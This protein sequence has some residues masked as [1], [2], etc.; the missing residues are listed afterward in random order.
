MKIPFFSKNRKDVLE[1]KALRLWVKARR[2]DLAARRP[3]DTFGAG[4]YQ[5]FF[6]GQGL[7]FHQVREYVPGDDVRFLDWNVTARMGHPYLKTFVEERELHLLIVLDASP[8]LYQSTGAFGKWEAALSAAAGLSAAAQRNRD[9]T[10]LLIFTDRVEVFSPPRRGRAAAYR[11]IREMVRLRPRA[12]KADWSLALGVA[13]RVL[14]R[15]AMMVAI[16]DFFE[17]LPE[18]TIRALAAR[19]ALTA[20]CLVHPFEE[21]VP[22]SARVSVFDPESG[23]FGVW[24]ADRGAPPA[25]R[26]AREAQLRL[27]QNHGG[28]VL[29]LRTGEDF[30]LG[31]MLHM[32]RKQKR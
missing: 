22:H 16:S 32:K 4:A 6:R 3:V 5:S 10:G 9:H 20:L 23:G 17:P 25:V 13:Q 26:E 29:R 7:E 8:S 28:D 1:E 24:R 15:R 21:G 18:G 30:S 27:W 12:K 31:W 19:H 11:M 2:L 14:K